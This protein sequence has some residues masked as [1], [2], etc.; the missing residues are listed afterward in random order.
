MVDSGFVV[1]D[2]GFSRDSGGRDA[3]FI[4]CGTIT[5]G[6]GERCETGAAGPMCVANTCAD[7]TCSATER[8]EPATVGTGF[9]CADISCTDDLRCNPDEYCNGM[10]CVDD[11]CTPGARVCG[12]G[13]AIEECDANGGGVS[14]RFSCVAG[15]YFT[16]ACVDDGSGDAHCSCADDW[17]CPEFTTCEAGRCIGSGEAPTC[18]LPPAPF[19]TVLPAPEPGFP[20]G[21]TAA[22]P[23]AT[24]SPFENSS[25]VVMTPLV[26]ESRRRQRGRLGR[27]SRLSRNRIP[28][29]LHRPEPKRRAPRGTRRRT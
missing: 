25:Q 21:G 4:P 13:G 15:A 19:D 3:G 5:C 29:V 23:A 6:P 27:R 7:I 9:Y 12:A 17:D 11:V 18:F 28:H 22:E 26:V 14:A 10:I 24:G 8:C 2:G 20:W 16:S 1:P